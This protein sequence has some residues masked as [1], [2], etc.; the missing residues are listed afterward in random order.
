MRGGEDAVDN[1]SFCNRK[2]DEGAGTIWRRRKNSMDRQENLPETH[3]EKEY[4]QKLLEGVFLM[5]LCVIQSIPSFCPRDADTFLKFARAASRFSIISDASISGSGRLSRSVR[6]L[7]LSQ[8]I[9]KL[10]LSRAINSS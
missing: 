4:V 10:V 9:S 5:L 6:L 7:S 3:G 1:H 8:K 2:S